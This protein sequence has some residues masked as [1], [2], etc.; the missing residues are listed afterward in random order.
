MISAAHDL[1]TSGH[2]GVFKTTE[3]IRSKF[4]FPQMDL[5]VKLYLAACHV[6]LKKRNN[7]PKLK[8]PLTPYNGRHPGHIV[9]MD[10]IENLPVANGY[11]SILV[12]CD[13]FSK[14]ATA[15]ALRDTKVE[16]VAKAFVTQWCCT[17][18]I[19]SQVHTDRGTNI[20]SAGFIK[21]VYGL[22]NIT[23]TAN[24]AYRP[25]TDGGVERLNRTIKNMLW[26]FCQQNPKN[27]VDSLDMVMLAYRTAVHSST[28]F[29]PFFLD[30]GR[31]PRLP[32]DVILGVAPGT[33]AGE[34]YGEEAQNLYDQMR[35]IFLFVEDTLQT[36]HVSSKQRYDS[37]AKVQ[38]FQVGSYVYVWKPVPQGCTYKK[39]YDHYRGPFR[40]VEQIT[41]HTYKIVLDEAK[42]KYDIVHMEMLK[43]AKIPAG[44]KPAFDIKHYADDLIPEGEVVADGESSNGEDVVLSEEEIQNILTPKVP[45]RA[46]RQG[47]LVRYPPLRRSTRIR[48]PRTIYQHTG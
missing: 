29:S 28:N 3:R 16:A 44:S 23:K 5:K 35:K 7:V 27:W 17:Q 18:S 20:D 21:A 41:A 36:K 4:Y 10:L 2:L 40:I 45:S 31:L 43:D 19:P 42:G 11:K 34:H 46:K 30:K 14:W 25:Q 13:T 15:T 1:T 12:I 32:L 26:K 22:L 6:C 38:T 24:T 37:K 39:F 48:A 33:R 8:A 9:Q 47:T